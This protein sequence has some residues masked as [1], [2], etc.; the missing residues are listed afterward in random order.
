LELSNDGLVWQRDVRGKSVSWLLGMAAAVELPK[1]F[2]RI[3]PTVRGF[4]SAYSQSVS[5][6]RSGVSKQQG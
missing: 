2:T 3:V 6:R 4:C 5:K 1:D